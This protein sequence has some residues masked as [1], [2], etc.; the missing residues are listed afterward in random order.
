MYLLPQVPGKF[1]WKAQQ[2][3]NLSMCYTEAGRGD[4]AAKALQRA[5]DAAAAQN[6]PIKTDIAVLQAS[7]T[8]SIP[9]SIGFTTSCIFR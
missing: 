6:L 2:L 5:A 1:E 7:A 4:D 9:Q 8:C 3:M